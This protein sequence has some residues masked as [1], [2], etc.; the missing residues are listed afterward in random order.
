MLSIAAAALAAPIA[1]PSGSRNFTPP[2]NVPNYFSNES[3]PFRGSSPQTAPTGI[4]PAYAAPAPA[5][6]AVAANRQARR[7]SVHAGRQRARLARGKSARHVQ[8]AH[9][10]S[11]HGGRTAVA[12]GK[13]KASAAAS[14]AAPTKVKGGKTQRLA[15][16][17][18]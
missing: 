1:E 18:G 15:R 4:A 17:H 6:Q 2:G 3:G 11:G 8:T 13:S 16:A 5:D 12:R 7:H 14:R 10:R 9:T